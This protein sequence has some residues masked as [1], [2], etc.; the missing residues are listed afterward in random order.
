MAG[1]IAASL[2]L[3]GCA[4][5]E[6]KT[7]SYKDVGMDLIALMDEKAENTAYIEAMGGSEALREY[8]SQFGVG[9]YSEARAV[10]KIEFPVEDFLHLAGIDLT[11][12]SENLQRD[13]TNSIV[14]SV[15]TMLNNTEGA[16]ALAS[17]AL[18]VG[19]TAFYGEKLE[20]PVVYLYQFDE[21]S[22]PAV[23]VFTPTEDDI[24]KA[25]S[26]F[27]TSKEI[28]QLSEEEIRALFGSIISKEELQELFGDTAN[29]GEV[30]ITKLD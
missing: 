2:L 15:S 5:G 16:L 1:A 10:Y 30:R 29:I 7:R 4:S 21:E 17:S 28:G 13:I 26:V 18:L 8:V 25:S 19:T 3:T 11:G 27:L 9:D 22:Y 23:V 12:M 14:S 20:T 24:V 6:R